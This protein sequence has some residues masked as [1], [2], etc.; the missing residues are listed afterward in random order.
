MFGE[1]SR[2]RCLKLP[3]ADTDNIE[4]STTMP[5]WEQTYTLHRKQ[6]IVCTNTRFSHVGGKLPFQP[7]GPLLLPADPPQVGAGRSQIH[8]QSCRR[9][10]SQSASV[11]NP[12]PLRQHPCSPQVFTDACTEDRDYEGKENIEIAHIWGF[13]LCG[14]LTV[15]E[16]I[17]MDCLQGMRHKHHPSL[18]SH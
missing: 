16:N 10:T 2:W 5:R 7:A 13:F 4:V 1:K 14:L 12:P 11:G 18:K 8:I 6:G 3:T 9:K 17:F 15:S